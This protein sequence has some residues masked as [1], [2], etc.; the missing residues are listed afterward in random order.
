MNQWEERIREFLPGARVGKI[1]AD[2]IDIE[3]KDIVLGM[4]QSLSMKKISLGF[5]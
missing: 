1:Q 4:L 2:T 3:G 5:I